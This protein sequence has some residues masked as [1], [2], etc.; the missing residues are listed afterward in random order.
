MICHL[1]APLAFGGGE[2]HLRNLLETTDASK[3][4]VVL[5]LNRSESLERFLEETGAEFEVVDLPPLPVDASLRL[6]LFRA[7]RLLF[8][9]AFIARK[10]KKLSANSLVSHGFPAVLVARMIAVRGVRVKIHWQHGLRSPARNFIEKV[11]GKWLYSGFDRVFCVSSRVQKSMDAWLS[12]NVSSVVLPPVVSGVFYKVH[13][14]NK[15]GSVIRMVCPGRFAKAKQQHLLLKALAALPAEKRTRLK[16]ILPGEGARR[17]FCEAIVSDAGMN[18]VVEFPGQL[19]VEELSQLYASCDY[20]LQ[21]SAS[22]GFGLTIAEGGACGLEA[23]IADQ[24]WSQHWCG[25]VGV[26]F[27]E[28]TREGWRKWFENAVPAKIPSY[29]LREQYEMFHA[30]QIEKQLRREVDECR[31]AQA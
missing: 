8:H 24:A 20:L 18:D 19:D 12:P 15:S 13:L 29:E 5:L 21:P 2:N 11:W 7:V 31:K 1:A 6:W 25:F 22:E 27:V 10:I 30:G 17:S 4:H 26:Q 28:N 3:R 23:V 16:L 9:W 14:K